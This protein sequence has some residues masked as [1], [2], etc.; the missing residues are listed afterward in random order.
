MRKKIIFSGCSITAGSGWIPPSNR[1]IPNDIELCKQHSNLWVNLC[2]TEIDQFNNLDLIN[3]GI[4]GASNTDI[5]ESTVE[6][7]LNNHDTEVIFVQWTGMPRYNFHVGLERWDT[8]ESMIKDNHINRL[9]DHNLSNTSYTR[10]HVNRLLDELRTMHHLHWE[11][12]K[13]LKYSYIIS[14]ICQQQGVNYYFINGLCPWDDG[15]FSKLQGPNLTPEDLTMF[16]KTAILDIDSRSDEDIFYLYDYIHKEY[17]QYPLEHN[18][19]INLYQSFKDV[20]VDTNYDKV[21][22]GTLSNI[23]FLNMIKAKILSV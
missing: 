4:G 1:A 9:Y 6:A 7:I 13:V 17:N 8:S 15:Y 12:I 21:H 16:T 20:C 22:P 3:I 18:R 2:H 10:E 19:W 11:I 14:K 5:F 23:K